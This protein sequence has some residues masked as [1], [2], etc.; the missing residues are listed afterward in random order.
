MYNASN[1]CTLFKDIVIPT[2]NLGGTVGVAY[3]INKYQYKAQKDNTLI[4]HRI[5]F[6]KKYEQILS[7]DDYQDEDY[8][9][10]G[11]LCH[12]KY[13]TDTDEN[14]NEYK[15]FKHII[16]Y[17]KN[18]KDVASEAR[19][20]LNLSLAK[21]ISL[22]INTMQSLFVEYDRDG[23][24]DRVKQAFSMRER[25]YLDLFPLYLKEKHREVFDEYKKIKDEIKDFIY[26]PKK[27]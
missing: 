13:I 16:K 22:L 6:S 7:F 2:L 17:K 24:S 19:L 27:N 10:D 15:E 9:C 18:L 1:I 11:P 26:K 14:G 4:V 20:L 5:N 3:L 12:I 25:K 21:E 8:D 23:Q